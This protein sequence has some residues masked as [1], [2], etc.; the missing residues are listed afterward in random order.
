MNSDTQ[1]KTNKDLI[2]YATVIA[3]NIH[4]TPFQKPLLCLLDSGSTGS[5]V[6]KK[7]LPKGINGKTVPPITTQTAMGEFTSNQTITLENLTLPE[8]LS[9]RTSRS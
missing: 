7:S 9:N 8:F 2:P 1:T 3:R 4:D 6:T 5:W